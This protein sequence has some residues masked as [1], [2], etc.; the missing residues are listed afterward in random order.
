[1]PFRLS[2]A[3]STF[4]RLMNELLKEFIGKFAIV[5]LDDILIYNKTKV[6]HLRHLN[7][8]LMKSHQDNLLVNLKKCSFMKE[9][10][11]YLGFF[12]SAEGLKMDPEKIKTIVEWPSPKSVFEVRIFHGLVSFYRKFIRN[13][14][15]IN[16]PIIETI[17]KDK[18][19][20]KWTAEA[21]RNFSVLEAKDN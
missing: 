19:P 10:L 21:E 15:K 17:N 6:E 11:V 2:N 12:V 8:L 16:A 13:F 3:P 7:Y 20:F 14:S 4:M 5:Y 9:E 18:Q 1:M